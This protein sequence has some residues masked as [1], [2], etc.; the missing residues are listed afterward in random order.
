LLHT[1][2]NDTI[3]LMLQSRTDTLT[4]QDNWETDI[5]YNSVQSEITSIY[6]ITTFFSNMKT[7]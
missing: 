6:H 2:V 5:Q 7:E 3:S 4:F 1:A